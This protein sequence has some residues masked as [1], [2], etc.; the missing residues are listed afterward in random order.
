MGKILDYHCQIE[1]SNPWQNTGTELPFPQ[2]YS[3]K[4]LMSKLAQEIRQHSG[5]TFCLLPF[6]HTLEA[7]A[8]GAHIVLGDEKNGPRV[9]KFAFSSLA[10]LEEKLNFNWDLP[11][12]Q[13]TLAA[14]HLLQEH[15]EKLIFQISGPMTILGSLVPPEVLYRS[16]RKEPER[17]LLLF[18]KVGELLLDLMKHLEQQDVSLFSYADPSEG[19]NLIGP[20]F[21]EK[22]AKEFT[23]GFLQKMD[24][25]LEKNSLVYLCPK[26]A[27]A[28]IGSGCAQ[29]KTHQLPDKQPY[30]EAAASLQ[31]K[32]RF[33][34]QSCI[35]RMDYQSD[36]IKEI[37][38]EEGEMMFSEKER[39]LRIIAKE[40]V[41]RPAC[42]CPGGMMNM[43]TAELMQSAAV[44]LPQVHTDA[45]KMAKLALESQKQGCFENVGVP[46]CMTVEAEAMGAAVDLGSS[47]IEPRVTA[48]V[49]NSVSEKE[50]LTALNLNSGRVKVVLDAISLL[51]KQNPDTPI[52]GNI[53]GP[54]STAASLMEPMTFYRE[55]RKKKE[56]A[57]AYLD[58]VTEQLCRFAAAQ[59]K[60]GADVIAI[61]DPSGTGE[62]LGPKYFEEF[63][64]PCL[65]QIVESAKEAGAVTIVHICGQM[66]AV[67]PQLQKVNSH[68]LSFDSV[69]SMQEA[70]ENLPDRILMGNVSTYTLEFGTPEKIA[71]LAEISVKN[72]ADLLAPACGLGMKTSLENE[73]AM[74]NWLKEVYHAEHTD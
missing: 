59:V 34:G 25:S 14:C 20:K 54:I 58:F 5:S 47:I 70:R 21:A 64:L 16:L 52:I 62:I 18:E 48:Y 24:K 31:G 33:V 32:I 12:L 45:E 42:I 40:K 1:N 56:E 15:G 68:V 10:E 38:W 8:L 57:H 13:E 69:V 41:D 65:N 43:I 30:R 9:R 28:L 36:H 46:F 72:G 73:K 2:V 71:K 29:W 4:E 7:E 23:L 55:L 22:I 11:R 50:Q 6:C 63:A 27:F 51:K 39:L 53:T 61:S 66:K 49:L 37:I 35:N 3:D 19:V 67:Y 26:T 60:A 44:N 17:L 74:L